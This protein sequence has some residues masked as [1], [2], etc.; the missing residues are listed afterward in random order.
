MA[1]AEEDALEAAGDAVLGGGVVDGT[2]VAKAAAD[3]AAAGVEEAEAAAG[4]AAVAAGVTAEL[5]GPSL[6]RAVEDGV[7]GGLGEGDVACASLAPDTASLNAAANYKRA[8]GAKKGKRK[9][10]ERNEVRSTPLKPSR[11]SASSCS[12][13][14][15]RP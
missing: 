10:V 9:R 6:C 7:I 2:G 4:E 11:T 15:P 12:D 13:A 8:R 14:K 5:A 1:A 3:A